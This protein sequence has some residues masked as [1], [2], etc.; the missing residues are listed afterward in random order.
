MTPEI[1]EGPWTRQHPKYSITPIPMEYDFHRLF[2]ISIKRNFWCYGREELR[3]KLHFEDKKCTKFP[4]YK[5]Y[6]VKSRLPF[7]DIC[8]GNGFHDGVVH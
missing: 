2:D 8:D 3:D 7:F 5:L 1:R 6:I 4:R